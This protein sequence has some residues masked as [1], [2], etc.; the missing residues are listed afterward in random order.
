VLRGILDAAIA[1]HLAEIRCDKSNLTP[2]EW[3]AANVERAET[4]AVWSDALEAEVA[5]RATFVATGS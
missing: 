3:Q 2:D 1:N 5:R 4:F